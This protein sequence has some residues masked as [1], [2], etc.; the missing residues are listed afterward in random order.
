MKLK[1]LYKLRK[2]TKEMLPGVERAIMRLADCAPDLIRAISN[3]SKSIDG[4]VKSGRPIDNVNSDG[5]IKL[6]D[7][8]T[9][10]GKGWDFFEEDDTGRIVLQRC[11]M[12]QKYDS[13][14]DAA[15]AVDPLLQQFAG[16]V[17]WKEKHDSGA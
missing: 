14:Q 11:D 6:D 2:E 5:S 15:I 4:Y 16:R 13:D 9:C 17:H 3:L 1:K 10:A 8:C 7:S 12:C